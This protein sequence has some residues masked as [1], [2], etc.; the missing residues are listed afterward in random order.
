MNKKHKT[1]LRHAFLI[2][3]F[4]SNMFVFYEIKENNSLKGSVFA[5]VVILLMSNLKLMKAYYFIAG[6]FSLALCYISG[7]F[8][9]L[10]DNKLKTLLIT[11][12]IITMIYPFLSLAKF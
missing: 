1:L 10:Y 6:M 4:F 2:V 7:K 9:K 5:V 11:L 3:V 12:I 8:L